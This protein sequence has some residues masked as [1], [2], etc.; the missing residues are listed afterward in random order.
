[1]I[2]VRSGKLQGR[3][4]LELIMNSD[5]LLFSKSGL[6]FAVCRVSHRLDQETIGAF[7]CSGRGR[8]SEQS[9]AREAAAP[10]GL[11]AM[12]VNERQIRAIA[13]GRARQK[14]NSEG[15][16]GGFNFKLKRKLKI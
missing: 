16:S 14:T 11:V 12:R 5:C 4:I 15:T 6:E 3:G 8:Q 2:A 1:M 9:L 10:A 13:R 7:S